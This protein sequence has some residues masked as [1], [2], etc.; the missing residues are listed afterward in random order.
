MACECVQ[1]KARTPG[2]PFKRIDEEKALQ[3]VK[4]ERLLT[5]TCAMCAPLPPPKGRQPQLHPQSCTVTVHWLVPE[6]VHATVQA[7]PHL[8]FRSR[9]LAWA[10]RPCATSLPPLQMRRRLVTVAGALRRPISSFR[11]GVLTGGVVLP[12]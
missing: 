7:T 5:N 9:L 3:S 4:D 10:H 8:L 11:C 12:L 1:G 2:T 6:V